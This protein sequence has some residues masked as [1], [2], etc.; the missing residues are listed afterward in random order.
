[1]DSSI[2]ANKPSQAECQ[3]KMAVLTFKAY[4]R[5]TATTGDWTSLGQINSWT[6]STLHYIKIV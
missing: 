2:L 3:N 1:M 4:G 5:S 6:V